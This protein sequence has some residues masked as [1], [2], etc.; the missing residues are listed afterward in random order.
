ME[1]KQEKGR[2][3]YSEEKGAVPDHGRRNAWTRICCLGPNLFFFEALGT[4]EE[5]GVKAGLCL[6]GVLLPLSC[7][8]VLQP[9]QSRRKQSTNRPTLEIL[10]S[11]S[12]T[13]A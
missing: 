4:M 1:G 7:S 10:K 11:T 3:S 13:M 5:I 2:L 6:T 8:G 12:T 9:R